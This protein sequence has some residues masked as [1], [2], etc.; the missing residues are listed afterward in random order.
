MQNPPRNPDEPEYKQTDATY[1]AV[2]QTLGAEWEAALAHVAAEQSRLTKFDQRQP[3]RPTAAQREQLAVGRGRARLW[4][5]PGASDNLKQ[6]LARVLIVEIVAD[7]DEKRS[8]VLLLIHWSG[9][10]HTELRHTCAS[11]RGKLTSAELKPII[12][13][14]C[15]VLDDASIAAALNREQTRSAE[16]QTWTRT[17][18]QSYRHSAGIAGFDATLKETS[19]WLTQSEAATRRKISPNERPPACL[20]RH[21]AGRAAQSRVADGHLGLRSAP[22]RGAASCFGHASRLYTS[23]T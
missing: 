10:H 23:A 14:L 7:V 17:R 13:M 5:H 19:G 8:E 2:R 9:G 16:G 1:A 20:Q 12:E 3:T 15:K 4:N 18:V 22:R 21:S 6:Q 11:P